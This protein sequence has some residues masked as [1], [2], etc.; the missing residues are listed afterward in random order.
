MSVMIG[1]WGKN[2]AIRVPFKIAQAAEL[3][4]GERVEIEMHDGNIVIHRPTA[5]AQA[6]AQTAAEEIIAESRHYTLESVSIHELLEE[7]RR[8]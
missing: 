6:T 2:L 5:Q 7:G 4:E 8:G 3:S 1:K